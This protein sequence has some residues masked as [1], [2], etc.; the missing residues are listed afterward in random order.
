M[1]EAY[2]TMPIPQAERFKMRVCGRP[3]AGIAGL[4]PVGDVFVCVL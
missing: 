4:N 2:G 3:L 1:G